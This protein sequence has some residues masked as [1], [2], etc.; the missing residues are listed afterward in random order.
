[1]KYSSIPINYNIIIEGKIELHMNHGF[2]Q[3]DSLFLLYGKQIVK[4]YIH[5]SEEGEARLPPPPPP[6]PPYPPLRIC[7]LGEGGRKISTGRS[8]AADG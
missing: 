8:P 6:P 4:R 3:K 5:R 7:L 1:M 2:R